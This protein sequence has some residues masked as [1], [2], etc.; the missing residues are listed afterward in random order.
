MA[1]WHLKLTFIIASMTS[2]SSTITTLGRNGTRL[3]SS[4]TS[5]FHGAVAVGSRQNSAAAI[6]RVHENRHNT[7]LHQKPLHF[8]L[9]EIGTHILAIRTECARIC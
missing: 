3:F 7:L 1:T 2:T 4:T 5:Y 6:A 8:G 9:L